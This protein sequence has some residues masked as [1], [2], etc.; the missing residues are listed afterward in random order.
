MKVTQKEW[1]VLERVLTEFVNDQGLRKANSKRDLTED[2]AV[3]GNLYSRFKL[4]L[5]FPKGL[6]P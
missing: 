1:K 2:Q 3:I 5:T 6:K 4:E